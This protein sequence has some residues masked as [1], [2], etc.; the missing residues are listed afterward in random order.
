MKMKALIPALAF[1]AVGALST[2]QDTS[3]TSIEEYN[4][5]LQLWG[6]AWSPGNGAANGAYY[7]SFY[8]G[9][10]MRQ[11]SP[12]RIH[13][14]TSR[15]NQ[16]RITVILDQ[17]TV[18]DYLFD[19]TKRAEFYNKVTS[20]DRP[21]YNTTPKNSDLMPTLSYFTD[22]IT[23]SKYGIADFVQSANAGSV[24]DEQIYSKGLETLKAL[25]PGRV[26]QLK[27]DLKTEFSNWKKSIQAKA[28][29][30]AQNILG[31]DSEVVLAIQTLLMGRVNMTEEPS[32]SVK[33]KLTNAVQM[34][35]QNAS[36]EQLLPVALDLFKA[37][38]GSK[39]DIQVVN[40]NGQWESAIQCD[41]NTCT[42]SYPEFTTIYPT[43]SVQNKISDEFG[44][45][46]NDFATP[47]L[48][49]F[50]NYSG[51]EVDNI[52]TEP[53]YGFVP[54]MDYE[55][56]G[57]GFHNP[58][59]RFSE[60]DLNKSI[61]AAFGMPDRYNTLWTVK[62]GGV[63]HGCLR[64]PSG[65]VWEMRQIFPVENSRMTQISFFGNSA[66]DFDVY[67]IDGDG[68]MEVMGVEY[69][70]NYNLEGAGDS[71]R[72]E[73][74]DLVV[75]T[76]AK[77]DYYTGLYGSKNVFTVEADGKY[78]FQNPKMSVQSYLDF[79][80]Q[81]ISARI[82]LQGDYPLYEMTYEKDKLQF[83]VL[84]GGADIGSSEKLKIR[85]MGRVRGCAPSSD[86]KAC[87]EAAFDKEAKDL[88]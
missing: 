52:R 33:A 39:Y 7:P 55:G 13:V 27:F 25:N 59:V 20:G 19:L 65:H 1:L 54:K 45:S 5:K 29:G 61:K 63:S 56:I 85:L 32:D 44:N 42:L 60:W 83:Y 3:V 67:D 73:G 64:L 26:F 22:I 50:L 10:A 48:W 77:T 84:P 9:F 36:D 24:S 38:T 58:A 21:T 75:S 28:A 88:L 82:A 40:E 86:K 74:Q 30:D 69:L 62:R 35:V 78:V 2:A 12:E 87:G 18:K 15:G 8:T 72:R 80:Q 71:A 37:A 68:K 4:D 34:A 70:I 66:R 43:G 81:R 53:Y 79:K 51:R 17:N 41:G 46:I 49:Q 76:D 11:Q 14:R 23:S 57:N 31:K 6:V 47:G 16:T